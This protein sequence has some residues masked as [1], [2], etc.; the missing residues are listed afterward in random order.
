MTKGPEVDVLDPNT[1][2]RTGKVVNIHDAWRNGYWIGTFNL[3]VVQ[4]VDGEQSILYQ[5]R[6]P[7]A[8]WAPRRLDVSVGGHYDAGEVLYDGLREAEEEIGRKY[9]PDDIRFIG[10]KL[11][12][13]DYG[14][15]YVRNVV[16]V[17]ITVDN[18]SLEEFTLEESEVDGLYRCRISDLIS[19][20]EGRMEA[21][22]ARG[23]ALREG[24]NIPDEISVDRSLFPYNW[25]NYHYKMAYLCRR[26]LDGDEPLFY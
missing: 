8:T 3:W 2:E 21:F 13:A 14:G 22:A 17:C 5:R 16:D 7:S 19:L 26:F 4:N 25:D 15:R 18:A 11:H 1:F 10:R 24:R 23:I 9:R 20:H 12:V 6:V